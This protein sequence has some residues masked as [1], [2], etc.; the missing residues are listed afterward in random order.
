MS[1]SGPYVASL[2][3][4]HD[5]KKR[6]HQPAE[7]QMATLKS[8][9]KSYQTPTNAATSTDAPVAR[10]PGTNSDGSFGADHLGEA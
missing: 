1:D 7:V 10:W 6:S 4:Q 3:M 5:S 9:L 8:R 2:R